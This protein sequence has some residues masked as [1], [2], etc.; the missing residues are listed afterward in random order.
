MA[1]YN[2]EVR[3]G[4]DDLGETLQLTWQDPL[5]L[6]SLLTEEELAIQ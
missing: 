4:G 2:W 6:N 3:L 1:K 5:N